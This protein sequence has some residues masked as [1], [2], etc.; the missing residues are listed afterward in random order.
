MK[1]TVCDACGREKTGT[2]YGGAP[3]QV[4]SYLCHLDEER[5]NKG[6][7]IDRHGCAYS[8]REESKDLCPDCYNRIMI[9]AVLEFERLRDKN[10]EEDKWNQKLEKVGQSLKLIGTDAINPLLTEEVIK[11]GPRTSVRKRRIK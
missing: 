1:T 3:W 6:H 4:L 8:G 9:K 2:T 5:R 7:H 11:E 10:L